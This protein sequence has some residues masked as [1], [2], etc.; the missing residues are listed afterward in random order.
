MRAISTAP[1][2]EVRPAPLVFD[3][4]F[5]ALTDRTLEVLARR[6]SGR[7]RPWLVRRVL[8]F[9]DAAALSLAF[10]LTLLVFERPLGLAHGAGGEFALFLAT[11]PCWVLL[12]ALHRLYAREV[13]RTTHP[14][15]DVAGVIHVLV[16]GVWLVVAAAA[17]GVASPDP[18]AVVLFSVL[19]SALV[20]GGRV[21]ARTLYRRRLSYVQNALIV[22]AG[23][24]GQLLARKILRHP[25][26]AINLVGFVDG[27]PL[28]RRGEAADF[29]V[30]GGPEELPDL[31][32]RLDVER[33]LLAFSSDRDEEMMSL[34]R[35]AARLGV[36]V[37]IVPRLFDVVSPG[38]AVQGLDGIPLV[39]ATPPAPSQA[40]KQPILRPSPQIDRGEAPAF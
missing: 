15:E 33:V 9:A 16:V 12:A 37:D 25:E 30:L 11:L 32:R 2:T 17:V 26:Y 27:R 28:A 6:S 14:A 29:P 10:A 31:V 22:G 18:P 20:P 36:Q 8:P 34:A 13:E 21:L 24:V 38:T 39:A 3:P 7:R 35:V 1:T 4:T 23:E 19:A 40:T 5:A